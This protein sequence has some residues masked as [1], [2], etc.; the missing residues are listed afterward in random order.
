M[1]SRF[2]VGFGYMSGRRLHLA[3]AKN[4]RRVS[5]FQRSD[6]RNAAPAR[7]KRTRQAVTSKKGSCKVKKTLR[8][9]GYSAMSSGANVE[10]KSWK[11]QKTLRVVGYFAT[12]SGAEARQQEV[13]G[14]A[15]PEG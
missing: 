1:K 7:T 14:T 3:M 2:R 13:S 12:S 8:T 5:T 11:V 6:A 15:C 9:V 4:P 10:R